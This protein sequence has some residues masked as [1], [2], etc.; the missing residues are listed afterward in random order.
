MRFLFRK[1]YQELEKHLAEKQ[2][3]VLTG[4]RRTG[5]TTLLLRLM[6]QVQSGNKIYI[7]LQRA[8]NRELFSEKNYDN[9]LAE[10]ARRGFDIKKKLYIFLDEIQLMPELPGIIKYLY[11]HYDI[12]FV[13]T[14]SS[15]YYMKN[16]FGE[17][18]AGR[19]KIF[20]LYP[21][22]FGEFLVFKNVKSSARDLTSQLG[23]D[24]DKQEYWQL[25]G[26]YDE[27]I[28]YGG[29]PEVALAGSLEKKRDLLNDIISSYIN[30]DVAA[31]S[32]FR[33]KGDFYNIIKMLA[34]RIGS[35][36][37]YE[38]IS[39]MLDID[40]ETL[41]NYAGFFEDTYL[42][43]R[44][45]VF[46]RNPDREIVK[47]KKLYFGDIGLAN[48]LSDLD[49][50]AKF[51]NAVF[52]Q[53]ARQGKVAHYSLKDGREIDFVF[54][55]QIGFE[56][57]ETPSEN[58]WRG[59]SRLVKTAGLKNCKLIGRNETAKFSDYIWGGSIQ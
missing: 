19:K 26:F 57:K 23:R 42:I 9:I 21:L 33:K 4:M 16:L 58:D 2:V 43:K 36:L 55:D 31:M 27:Y 17:S 47:A 30:I 32:D 6:E 1:I 5:K 20:E 40:A 46:T 44:V 35:R 49:S 41:K 34:S 14:G 52:C 11:D 37:D 13:I 28:E 18:L 48:V 25:K 24:F 29:F 7:D 22:D 39:S 59:L 56:A 15:S 53:L 38:K 54:N 51:E 50:G 3:T 8:D 10:F 12:K 45:P